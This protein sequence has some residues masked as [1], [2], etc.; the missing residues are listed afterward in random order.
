MKKKF[1]SVYFD[2]AA[3]EKARAHFKSAA[4]NGVEAMGLLLGEVCRFKGKKFVMVV[5]YVT[6]GNDA[7]AVSVRFGDRAFPELAN[8]LWGAA[9][10]T[11][12]GWMHSHPSYGCYL[13]AR[14]VA[15]QEGFFNEPFHVAF[16]L[17]PVRNDCKAFR[18]RNGKQVE[19]SFA[20]V[21][22]K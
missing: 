3:F 8:A 19:V 18:V 7:S 12:V 6:A 22:E 15:A 16:V 9:G 13:S 21:E 4:Q 5:D 1:Y 14:D 11:V 2:A 17:D 20:V 10:K